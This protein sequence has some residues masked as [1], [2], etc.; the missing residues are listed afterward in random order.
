MEI[1]KFGEGKVEVGQVI[2][3]YGHPYHY[4]A[5]GCVGRNFYPC[6]ANFV[7]PTFDIDSTYTCQNHHAPP[8]LSKPT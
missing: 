8:P 1:G 7:D 5:S 2:M 3:A 6:S 4:L